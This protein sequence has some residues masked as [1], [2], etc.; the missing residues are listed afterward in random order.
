MVVSLPRP[1]GSEPIMPAFKV[2]LETLG[3]RGV[4]TTAAYERLGEALGRDALG[5]I[6]EAGIL[7]ITVKDATDFED[8]LTRVWDAVARAGAD[9]AFVFAEHPDIPEHWRRP[10]FEGP[11]GA[12]S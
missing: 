10:G 5:D 2:A 3:H 1:W 9:D 6:D 12:L 4:R 11:P 7:E 8:A